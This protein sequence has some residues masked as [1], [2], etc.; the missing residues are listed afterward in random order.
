MPAG[1]VAADLARY[2]PSNQPQSAMPLSQAQQY[3]RRLARGHYENF[4]VLSVLVPRRLRQDF[5]NLYA[6]CRWSDDLADETGDPQRSLEL[7]DW[8][9]QQLEACFAGQAWHPVFV[10]LADTIQRHP[11]PKQPLA[12]LLTA[13]RQ[14]QHQTR[15]LTFDD[16]L[17]YCRNS[18]NPVGRLVLHLG[19]AF[20]EDRAI[21]SDSICTGLQLA[22]FC[23]DVTGDWDRGRIYLPQESLTRFAYSEEDFSRRTQNQAFR[24]LLAFEVDRARGYLQR[25]LPLCRELPGWL[26]RDVRLMARGGMAVLDAIH[27]ADYRIWERRPKVGK[28]TQLRL[29]AGCLL[30]FGRGS[31]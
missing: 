20:T 25:G 5:A 18:A 13:F 6:Y 31:A 17:G 27:R 4:L 23:Q 28:L 7:L 24:Q 11:L 15:Y 30:P 26:G 16:L 1:A 22:N 9:Q 19:D 21:A 3:C 10:A 12:D 8:W 14:D 29:L 2:G